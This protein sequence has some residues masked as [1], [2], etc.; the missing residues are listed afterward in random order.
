MKKCFKIVAAVATV[1]IAATS[2]ITFEACSKKNE[3]AKNLTEL[4]TNHGI[5][6]QKNVQDRSAYIAEFEKKLKSAEKSDESLTK[7]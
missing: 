6:Y 4:T 2:A 5:V 7:D 3:A 1:L